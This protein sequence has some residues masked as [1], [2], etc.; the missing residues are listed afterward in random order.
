MW[1]D[2][3]HTILFVYYV[4]NTGPQWVSVSKAGPVGPAGPPGNN[5][6]YRGVWTD[7]IGTLL[8]LC[9]VTFGSGMVEMELH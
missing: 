5:T 8:I 6:R 3:N 2:S 9:L 7:P 4:D 1:W